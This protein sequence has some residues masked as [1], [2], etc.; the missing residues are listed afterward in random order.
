MIQRG[1]LFQITLLLLL[2]NLP[3]QLTRSS[4]TPFGITHKIPN[5][6]KKNTQKSLIG[7]LRSRWFIV[8]PVDLHI[9]YQSMTSMGLLRLSIVKI[10]P[11]V[12]VQRKTA[13]VVGTF[14]FHKL[15]QV[16]EDQVDGCKSL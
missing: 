11:K 2:P 14:G 13:T 10:F 7:Q 12:A 1:I 5:K 9:Q 4:S 16:K 15:F 8:S 3:C 6:T